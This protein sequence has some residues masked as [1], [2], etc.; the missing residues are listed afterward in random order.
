MII[1]IINSKIAFSERTLICAP[2]TVHRST[3]PPIRELRSLFPMSYAHLRRHCEDP[4]RKVDYPILLERG[5]FLLSDF[6]P[7]KICWMPLHN[8]N[9]DYFQLDWIEDMVES[10]AD[11]GLHKKYD[12]A[13]PALGWYEDGGVDMEYVLE[14]VHTVFSDSEKHMDYHLNY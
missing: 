8:R 10:I 3:E 1:T 11:A 12:M 9:V 7:Q 6:G 14:L 13:F 4:R 2:V 5:K